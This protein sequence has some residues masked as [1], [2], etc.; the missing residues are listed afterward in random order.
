MRIIVD[1]N[2]IFSAM[3]NTNSLIGDILLNSQ[4]TFDF[5]SCDYLKTELANHKARILEISGYSKQAYTELE[6]I[7]LEQ[8]S[9][10]SEA[11]IPFEHWKAAAELVREVDIDDIALVALSLF[12][13]VVGLQIAISA[14]IIWC[15]Q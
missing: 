15:C 1:S 14:S 11:L 12:M 8:V 4:S 6:Y 10:L 2:I 3:L 13:G 7:L 5:I 9:F